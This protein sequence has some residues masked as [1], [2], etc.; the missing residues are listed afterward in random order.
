MLFTMPNNTNHRQ[1]HRGITLIEVMMSTMVVSLGILG[2]VALIP[3]GTHLTERGVQADRVASLGERAYHE[4]KARGAF[5]P[6]LWADATGSGIA[7]STGGVTPLPLR[8]PYLIDPMFFG[9]NGTSTARGFFPYT[10]QYTEGIAMPAGDS[11]NP[12]KAMRMLRLS[13]LR[14]SSSTGA[15]SLAQAKVG[16]QSDDDLAFERPDDGDLPSFQRFFQRGTT[17]TFVKRQA[18]GEYTWM[19][20]L[21]PELLDL[22]KVSHAGSALSNAELTWLQPPINQASGPPS[23]VPEI[24]ATLSNAATDE[25]TASVIIMKNRQGSIPLDVDSSLATIDTEDE[26]RNERMLEVSSFLSSGGYSTGEVELRYTG[27]SLED[28][29]DLYLDFSNGDWICLARRAPNS[30]TSTYGSTYDNYPTG[31]IYQWYRVVL[32][33]DIVSNSGNFTR[34]L[35]ISGPDWPSSDPALSPSHAIVVDG[36]VGVYTKRVKLETRTP[37]T[38]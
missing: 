22:S 33:D 31:D 24:N 20:M 6:N 29:E 15:L 27:S 9:T 17:P 10:T 23:R 32:V 14:N 1:A 3:L 26:R 5:N 28:A 30:S 38:P 13:L 11:R 18:L 36:V 16:F 21:T 4:A 7:A 12:S 8:Q 19:I 25:Y 34:R 37:W 35:S 2:L